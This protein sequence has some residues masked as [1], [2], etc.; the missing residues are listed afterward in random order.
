MTASNIQAA[1]DR[2][3]CNFLSCLTKAKYHPRISDMNG[4]TPSFHNPLAGWFHSFFI[5]LG[6]CLR[7]PSK[8]SHIQLTRGNE[9]SRLGL[10][11][12]YVR[13]HHQGAFEWALD[14][15]REALS[16]TS[17]FTQVSAARFSEDLNFI[18][19]LYFLA[20]KVSTTSKSI[21]LKARWQTSVVRSPYVGHCIL[22]WCS[23]I[24]MPQS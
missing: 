24:V 16:T 11:C 4:A 13:D 1:I 6:Q 8:H 5:H 7:C 22:R 12:S 10:P 18:E 14:L 20:L 3:L 21:S 9:A 23:Q 15:A 2:V 19:S 17:V